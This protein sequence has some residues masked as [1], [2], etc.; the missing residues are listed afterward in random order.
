[1][2]HIVEFSISGL[3]GRKQAYAQ[4]L[5]EDV[6][7]FF[8][9]NGSGKTSLLKIF[10]SAMSGDT[11]ILRNVPFKHAE[12]KLFSVQANQILTCSIEQT[13]SNSRREL[14]LQNILFREG[15]SEGMRRDIL[16]S[17]RHNIQKEIR[18]EVTPKKSKFREL[19]HSYLPISRPYLTKNSE[20]LPLSEEQ[21]DLL[22][23]ENLQSLWRRYSTEMLS[24]IRKV[25]EDGLASILKTI[26]SAN[27]SNS[28]ANS[29]MD[30]PVEVETAYEQMR[31]FLS[32]Q[33]A[34]VDILGSLENFTQRYAKDTRLQQVVS[35]IHAVEK[36]IDQTML[37]RQ[38]LQKLIQKM[39][40]HKQIEFTDSDI[41]VKTEED[42]PLGLHSLS[43]GERELMLIFLET[44]LAGESTIL[45]DEPEMSMHI[46]WQLELVNAMRQLN[47]KAQLILATHS[48]EIMAEVDDD[49]VFRLNYE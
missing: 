27:E 26:L 39:F 43:S 35:D 12:V 7:I 29:V 41:L 11:D 10:H 44:F 2:S 6:N 3:A 15:I 8:G 34:A 31:T 36:E 16:L 45:I 46:D 17:H 24:N 37:P 49:K 28:A 14:N 9:L 47:P 5:N 40:S 4:K 25:Q 20:H 32:R 1:M 38:N 42:E 48:P 19:R 21:L 33:K 23:A 22:F 13:I 30:K 18:W